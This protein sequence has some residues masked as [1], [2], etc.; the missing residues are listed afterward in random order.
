GM[1]LRL[2]KRL[3]GATIFMS[4]PSPFPVP[5]TILT[6]FLGAGKTTLLNNILHG[7]HG[8]RI[9]VLVN[10]FGAINI[11]SEL[12]VGV[13]G[14]TVNLSN[15]C[16]C[17][18]IRDDLMMET[19]RLL[20]RPEPPQYIIVETSGVSDPAAVAMT[21]L[22]PEI[23]P[24]IAV[25]SILTIV[26]SEQ[27]F[28]LDDDY[29]Q[30]AMTQI[31][32]ADIVVLNKVDRVSPDKLAEVRAQITNM[33]PDIRILDT[34]YG[35]IPLELVLG[36]GQY[37]PEKLAEREASDIHV[38]E[39]GEHPDHE[40]GEH[41][42]EHSDHSLVFNTW[43]WTSAEPLNLNA[44]RAMVDQLPPTIF[45]CKGIL[46][47]TDFPDR[48]AVLQVVGRRAS[49][50]LG[51]PWGD[52]TPTSQIVVIASHG[53]LDAH[54]LKEN[55]DACEAARAAEKRAAQVIDSMEWERSD[56]TEI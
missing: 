31:D 41:N 17:C 50:Q 33:I 47:L 28:S 55:F 42:H 21:F 18:T 32:V 1:M 20:K 54:A 38:H 22:M 2:N 3:N 44:V 34:T 51:D 15:G 29:A 27:L 43:S 10:D 46:N 53:G 40:H 13:E 52:A 25:D 8:L 37:A 45:R 39:A 19:V 48:R 35:R 7:D 5:V 49:L 4:R 24:Y 23:Q 9:A 26:D 12:I 11:D 36:V 6:G 16:I 56:Y 30:V 14:E